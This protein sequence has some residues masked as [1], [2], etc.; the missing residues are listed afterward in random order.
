MRAVQLKALVNSPQELTVTT[1]PDPT[2]A[3]DEY[4]IAVHACA[5]NFFDTLQ[6]RGKYQ[7]QPTLP[8]VGGSEFSGTVVQTPSGGG[9]KPKFGKGDKVFGSSQGAFATRIAVKEEH[10][11]AIP[12]GWSFRDAA[13]LYLTGPTSY[14]AMVVRANIQEGRSCPL[15]PCVEATIDLQEEKGKLWTDNALRRTGD[16]AL[17]HGAAGGVGIAAVQVAKAKGA[18]VI[19]TA[20]GAR[21]TAVLKSF[22]AD[23]VIDYM[24]TPA[25]EKEVMKLTGRHGADV[26]FDPVG[27]ISQSLKCAAFSA[28]LVPIGFVGGVIESIKVNRILLKNVS[29]AGLHWGA[30]VQHDPKTIPKVWAGLFELIEQ[31]KFRATVFEAEDGRPYRGL[32][33]VGRAI[34][35]LEDKASWGKVVV[36]IEDEAQAK[37]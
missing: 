20:T 19:A 18:N 31:G 33:D 21:N 25:W 27:T 7:W 1:V 16:W 24:A 11:Q 8:W 3:A 13:A 35:T 4:L 12:R 9:E 32:E 5:A 36:E 37:L 17:V 6:I 15:S 14:A 2:P 22:G 10:L 29:V 28:R 34:K 23:H 26:V 30:Y